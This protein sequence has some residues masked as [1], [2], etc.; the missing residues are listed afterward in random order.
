VRAGN[1]IGGGDWSKDRI[2][3]D[4]IRA[5]EK[6]EPIQIRNRHSVRPWEHV[7]E[8]LSGYLLLAQK[9]WEYPTE[10]C[11]G[12][13]FGPKMD[14]VVPVWE[15]ATMLTKEM[16]RGEL[17]DQ[18][19]PNAPHEAN[20]LMLDITKAQTRLNWHPRLSTAEAISLTADWYKRYQHEEVYALCVE[21]I[22]R[23]CNK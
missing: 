9:M 7:L 19:D 14:A 21:E 10:Y 22:K 2:I 13:N 12:W 1:V 6:G 17:L 5:I 8:P 15:V 20:L 23:F 4:C 16:G 3:P 11:E 18:T